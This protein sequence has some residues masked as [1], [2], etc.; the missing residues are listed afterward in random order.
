MTWELIVEYKLARHVFFVLL[1]I[2]FIR[3]FSYAQSIPSSELINQAKQYD[4]TDVSFE[5][6]VIG[7][8][9]I[10]REFVWINVNDGVNAVGIWADKN[11]AKQV[12]YTGSHNFRGDTVKATGVFHRSCPEH[13]GDLDIHAIS[14]E[15]TNSGMCICEPMNKVKLFLAIV[16]GGLCLILIL[17]RFRKS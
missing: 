6:E 4:N 9:M 14:V 13:G 16:L 2:L 17:I 15:K 5:G 12:I 10:R 1:F 8:I 7:D 11:L 3:P